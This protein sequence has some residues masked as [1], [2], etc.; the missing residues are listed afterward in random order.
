MSSPSARKQAFEALSSRTTNPRPILTSLNGDASWLLSLPLPTQ[1]RA[2]YNNRSYYHLV[3]EPWLTGPAILLFSWLVTNALPWQPAAQNGT[4][5]EAIAR[6]IE[7]AAG[8]GGNTVTGRC[9]DA[10]VLGLE[11]DDHTHEPTLKTFD[12]TIPVV[13]FAKAAAAVRKWNYFD[14]VV[15]ISDLADSSQQDWRSSPPGG[16]GGSSVLPD[17]LRLFR[18]PGATWLTPALTIIWSHDGQDELILSAP[19]GIDASVPGIQA[20]KGL[21]TL[22]LLNGLKEGWSLGRQDTLGVVGGLAL[23]RVL[24]PQYWV[25]SGDAQLIYEGVMMK[26]LW[27]HDEVRTLE[28]GL[29]QEVKRG[30]GKEGEQRRPAITGVSNG[31]VLVLE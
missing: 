27:V 31:E 26:L 22:A 21:K 4:D 17:W 25:P 5:V 30:E 18:L 7:D 13:G 16:D 28:W 19:H 24:R 20:L 15:S 12:P 8:G 11:L 14:T 3:L 10:I 1:E 6:E 2:Q 23:E 29:E 9:L